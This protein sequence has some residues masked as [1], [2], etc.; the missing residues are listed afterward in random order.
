MNEIGTYD[1]FVKSMKKEDWNYLDKITPHTITDKDTNIV[2]KYSL[3]SGEVGKFLELRCPSIPETRIA[4]NGLIQRPELKHTISIRCRDDS[5]FELQNKTRM[6][7]VLYGKTGIVWSQY[8]FYDE[9]C[10]T[11]GERPKEEAEKFYLRHE[12]LLLYPGRGLEFYVDEPDIDIE[13]I[14]FN[15]KCDI[16]VKK[17]VGG[18]IA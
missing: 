18:K 16:F 11:I 9:I 6:R 5:G 3:K 10:T 12:G 7:M 14:E 8:L 13:D 4:I 15:L 17:D 2:I 1:D